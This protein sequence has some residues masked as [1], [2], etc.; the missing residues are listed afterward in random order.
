MIKTYENLNM[1][2]KL[3]FIGSMLFLI[4]FIL[5]IISAII[6][7]QDII[8]G[9]VLVLPISF[10]FFVFGYMFELTSIIVKLWVNQYGKLFL[11]WFSGIVLALSAS[12][13]AHMINVAFKVSP[14]T[15]IYS[16]SILTV[17]LAPIFWFLFLYIIV[18]LMSVIYTPYSTLKLIWISVCYS[19]YSMYKKEDDLEDIKNKY[20]K[21]GVYVAGRAIGMIMAVVLF[22]AIF[23]LPSIAY[24]KEIN[25]YT[26]KFVMI[27][28]FYS[29]SG[30][31]EQIPGSRIAFLNDRDVLLINKLNG[32]YQIIESVCTKD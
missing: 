8:R 31:T 32:D 20:D 30:C 12:Y 27:F 4:N 1:P 26:I 6:G 28:D 9:L 17:L 3:Y 11:I 21:D 23:V 19:F 5:I 25:Y 7:Q 10:I 16:I 24:Q 22:S 29:Y 14:S 15:F 2:G 13:A 18:Q